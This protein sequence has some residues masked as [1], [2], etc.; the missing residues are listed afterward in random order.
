MASKRIYK[1]RKTELLKDVCK[2]KNLLMDYMIKKVGPWQS[3][4]FQIEKK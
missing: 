3:V 1:I 2:D 4:N